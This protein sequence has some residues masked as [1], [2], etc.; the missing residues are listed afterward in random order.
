M[1]LRAQEHGLRSGGVRHLLLHD[2]LR[3]RLRGIAACLAV[4]AVAGASSLSAWRSPVWWAADPD[5]LYFQAK[6]LKFRGHNERVALH[7]LF[8]GPEGSELRALEARAHPIHPQFTN[9]VW[10]DYTSRFFR[11]RVF[12]PLL[13]AAVYPLFG[14]RSLLNVSLIGYLLLAL[15]IYALL[16]QRFSRATSVAATC[17]CILSPPARRHGLVPMSDSWSVLLETCALFAAVLVLERRRVWLIFWM[18]VLAAASLT[19]DVTVVPLVA[20]FLLALH[21][22]FRRESL[23]L[24]GTG[25]AAV[26]PA[27]LIYGNTSVREN[28]AYVFNASNPPPD[29]SWGFVVRHY[30]PSL[31]QLARH[32][33]HYGTGLGWE[34]PLWFLGLVV[35]GIGTILLVRRAVRGDSFFLLQAYAIIGA[36]FFVLLYDS[37]SGFREELAFLPPVAVSLALVVRQIELHLLDTIR[38]PAM[39]FRP[40]R[41]ADAVRTPV[42]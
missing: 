28:L 11:R 18:A 23:T 2:V 29:S 8:A 6:V 34:T 12:V 1:P 26:L 17:V 36:C 39:L 24:F 20:V 25:V 41:Q 16:R 9:P 38:A 40:A 35:T 32:D 42:P 15:A 5:S 7:R 19:R 27:Y 4:V 22:R 37:Y 30:L 10:I 21:P 33:L 13:A 31:R 3:P 14:E